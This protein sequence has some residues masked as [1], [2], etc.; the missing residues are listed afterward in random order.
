MPQIKHIALLAKEPEKLAEFYKATFGM[1]EVHRHESAND[2]GL[3]VYLSDGHINLAFIPA[4]G[5]P[6]GM[7]HFGFQVESVEETARAAAAGG[8]SQPPS[9]VPQDGRFNEVF[10]KDPVGTRVDLAERGWK[11]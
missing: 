1:T 3:A 10:I 4:L 2:E 9:S 5:R 6:E 7:Y 11:T 8:A